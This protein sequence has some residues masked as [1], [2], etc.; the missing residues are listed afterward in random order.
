MIGTE[1]K[2]VIYNY[3]QGFKRALYEN[4]EITSRKKIVVDKSKENL[5]KDFSKEPGFV[6]LDFIH[7]I[8]KSIDSSFDIKLCLQYSK[9]LGNYS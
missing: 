5:T 6:L 7:G 2:D 3:L 9:I 4:T 8:I 1:K